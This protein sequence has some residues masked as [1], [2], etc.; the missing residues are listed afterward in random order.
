MFTSIFIICGNNIH[1]QLWIN[2]C[3]SKRQFHN[4]IF[5][6]S[7]LSKITIGLHHPLCNIFMHTSAMAL[8][9]KILHRGAWPNTMQ[10]CCSKWL[11]MFGT[12][13]CKIQS[14]AAIAIDTLVCDG[15][16]LDTCIGVLLAIVGV[17]ASVWSISSF[18]HA[19]DWAYMTA[20]FWLMCVP[21]IQQPFLR[22]KV[23]EKTI[24]LTA[25]ELRLWSSWH[26]CNLGSQKT[27]IRL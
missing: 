2:S 3:Q 7:P 19:L 18:E 11:C 25:L 13:C 22:W 6:F 4:W 12:T 5:T 9:E 24:C 10:T 8:F 20:Y 16:T 1:Q 23:S 21:R 14:S 17:P 15:S 27:R 26:Y